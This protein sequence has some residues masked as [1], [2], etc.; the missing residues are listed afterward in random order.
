M[1][2]F[3]RKD[4]PLIHTQHQWSKMAKQLYNLSACVGQHVYDVYSEA[5]TRLARS[6]PPP[7]FSLPSSPPSRWSIPQS[8]QRSVDLFR[9]QLPTA[10]CIH[11]H[12]R[13]LTH[14][15]ALLLSI[16]FH[17]FLKTAND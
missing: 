8:I 2:V 14:C 5:V 13:A 7:P 17:F 16:N 1:N 15:Y 9:F 10:T 6:L 11:T 12:T 3:S 4:L